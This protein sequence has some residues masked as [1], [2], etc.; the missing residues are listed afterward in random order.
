MTACDRPFTK[1]GVL[2]VVN[3]IYDP[4]GFISPITI[5]GKMLLRQFT[6]ENIDWDTPLP[7]EKQRK[8]EAWKESLKTVGCLQVPRC[9]ALNSLSDA[10]RRE[11]HIFSD[12]S[13]EAIAA[14]AYLKITQADG[15]PHC[16]FVLGKSKLT[17]KPAHSVP[18]L[19]LCAAMLAVE[20]GEI[21][22]DEMDVAIDS[23]TFYTDS[24]VVLG[25]IYNETKQFYVY[26]SNRVERIRSFSTPEQWHYIPT[27]LNPAD[28]GTRPTPTSGLHIKQWLS[29][30]RL[31]YKDS[32]SAPVNTRYELIGP[33]T[34]KEVR[35]T[36]S[37]LYTS[38][39]SKPGLRSSRFHRFSKWSSLVHA[40]AR[41]IHIAHCFRKDN[42]SD[43]HSWQTCNKYP[44]V[45]DI[46]RAEEVVIWSAQQESY[47]QEIIGIT[48]S[49]N[50][51]KKSTLFKLNPVIDNHKLLRVG[52]RIGKTNM[53]DKE[54]NPI[55]I[56]GRHYIATLLVR[57]HHE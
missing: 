30:P 10:V 33:E 6:T 35:P 14:V 36:I 4:L 34:D 37:P 23:F 55:I 48:R 13:I 54:Q 3:S 49:N 7:A 19:E 18:R 47:H 51:S 12:A 43:C 16:A 2:S 5:H 17:P 52:G 40:I 38:T 26:V 27:D 22:Q 45:E 31:L 32:C 11:I 1:R 41:L 50:L 8:W 46:K 15:V 56:P 39:I 25:Y 42:P 29:A 28:C 20:I 24:K 9:Y 44:T 21:I 57:H 53:C